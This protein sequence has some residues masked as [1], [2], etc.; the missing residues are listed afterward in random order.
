[1]LATD[2]L[3]PWPHC[4]SHFSS[5]P[6][7]LPVLGTAVPSTA[8][9]HFDSPCSTPISTSRNKSHLLT[10][11][12]HC[13]SACWWSICPWDSGHTCHAGSGHRNNLLCSG[14][15]ESQRLSNGTRHYFHSSLNKG[16]KVQ[17]RRWRKRKGFIPDSQQRFLLSLVF[18]NNWLPAHSESILSYM[19]SISYY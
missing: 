4:P 13:R 5:F 18:T 7:F 17:E 2:R 3:L 1:M 15:A 16:L 9:N 10:H 14:T 11:R 8:P 12:W 19:P 6:P